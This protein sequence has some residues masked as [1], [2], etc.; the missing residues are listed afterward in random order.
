M[1]KITFKIKGESP[2]LMHS[3]RLANPLDPMTKDH[4][5]LT[6]IR[7]KTDEDHEKIMKSEF[8]CSLYYDYDEPE[9]ERFI[10]IPGQNVESMLVDAAKKK[11]LGKV[12]K[13]SVI[14][15]EDKIKLEY[16][17]PKTPEE[18]FKLEKFLDV[19]GVRV[20]GARLMRCRPKFDKWALSVTVTYMADALTKGDII[21]AMAE[22][23]RLI[24]LC[25]YRPKY[26]RF[27]VEEVI[28]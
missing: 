24:G 26:G 25:D 5:K 3:A 22:S 28:E 10:Y 27:T 4:K 21:K 15:L 13:S 12:F 20:Q 16:D 7:K 6:G 19:Q 2:L 18:L 8:F 23:G 1:S 11:K 9:D 14:V 17:G